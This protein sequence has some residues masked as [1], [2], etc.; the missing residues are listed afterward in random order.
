MKVFTYYHDLREIPPYIGLCI[1]LM[2]GTFGKDFTLWEKESFIREFPEVRGDIWDFKK[3]SGP[4]FHTHALRSDYVRAHILR[5]HG[6]VWI[7]ADTVVVQDFTKEINF[8]LE[9]RDYVGR[10]NEVGWMAMNFMASKPDGEVIT[11]FIELQNKVL[12][13]AREINAGSKF[14]SRLLT[15]V[16]NDFLVKDYSII[17]ELLIAPINFKEYKEY[18]REDLQLSEFSL[19]IIYCFQLYNRAFPDEVRGMSSEE[20]LSKRWFVSRLINYLLEK[21]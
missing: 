15:G 14:G 2:E 11:K 9:K 21:S 6:G 8:L 1:K 17:P 3:S 7:D 12:D 10:R 18:F 20:F 16:M 4:E 13:G 5:K 19:E